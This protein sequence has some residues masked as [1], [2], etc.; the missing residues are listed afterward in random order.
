MPDDT[1]LF[2]AF[3]AA[4]LTAP[5]C[6]LQEGLQEQLA[7]PSR[8]IPAS[9][10]HLTLRFL[11]Q[12]NATQH[13]SLL[14]QLP[15][16]TLSGF[17]LQL[18]KL[19]Y[20]PSANVLWLGPSEV[21][22]ALSDLYQDLLLRCASLRLAPPHKAYRPHISLYRQTELSD[23]SALPSIS[24]IIFRPRQLALYSSVPSALG[25]DYHIEASWPLTDCEG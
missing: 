23:L 24:P 6:Q 7:L 15:T 16:L 22:Q 25:H 2:L 19:G 3:P 1:R 9:Q 5:L 4:E 8:R 18:D 10:F 17:T 12:L 21:P 11:G 14:R 20:F 13:H